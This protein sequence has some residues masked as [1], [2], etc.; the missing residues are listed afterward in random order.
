I[1]IKKKIKIL[2][3]PHKNQQKINKKSKLRHQV[4]HTQI[5]LLSFS[6]SFFTQKRRERERQRQ[7]M[8]SMRSCSVGSG[9]GLGGLCRA[10]MTTGS[11]SSSSSLLASSSS[12]FLGTSVASRS[13]AASA[14]PM[15]GNLFGIAESKSNSKSRS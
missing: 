5:H 9:S 1:K 2:L 7:R 15:K 8:W 12:S 13:M 11:R 14:T 3:S 4:S 6:F 10:M